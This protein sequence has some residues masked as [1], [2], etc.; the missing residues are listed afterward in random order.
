ML[1]CD[2][3]EG[4]DDG[5]QEGCG[6]TG[7]SGC[8]AAAEAVVGTMWSRSFIYVLVNHSFTHS[9]IHTFVQ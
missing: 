3:V 7:K 4:G 2:G 8:G 1:G 6:R 5:A 9:F